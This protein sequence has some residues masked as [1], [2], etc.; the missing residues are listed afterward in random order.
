MTLDRNKIE[1]VCWAD[2]IFLCDRPFACGISTIWRF[3]AFVKIR[4]D[5]VTPRS[6]RTCNGGRFW[7]LSTC[8]FDSFVISFQL[9]NWRG[10]SSLCGLSAFVVCLAVCL[11]VHFTQATRSE[12]IINYHDFLNMLHL[13][14]MG[15]KPN[16]H[17]ISIATENILVKLGLP[18]DYRKC[19]TSNTN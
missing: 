12:E 15:W 19:K 4:L 17:L 5:E 2:V 3:V 16:F 8:V 13:I 18:F 9:L 11:S 6:V 14:H 10:R 7:S 1:L